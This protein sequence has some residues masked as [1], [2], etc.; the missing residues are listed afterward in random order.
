EL[1]GSIGVPIHVPLSLGLLWRSAP[2]RAA[3]AGLLGGFAT[4]IAFLLLGLAGFSEPLWQTKVATIAFVSSAT[5]AF[6]A[7]VVP[8]RSESER[9]RVARFFYRLRE[10]VENPQDGCPS[11][12]F[13]AQ[14]RAIGAFGGFIALLV[15]GTGFVPGQVESLPLALAIAAP[16]AAVAALLFL[17][18]SARR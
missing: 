3:W 7:I 4:S 8:S 1:M 6:A 18:A 13:A 9:L 15:A 16:I 11:A 2:T 17:S 10:P 5:F 12:Q 14:Q